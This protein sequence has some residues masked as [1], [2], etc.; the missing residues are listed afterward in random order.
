MTLEKKLHCLSVI[1]FLN[2]AFV[3]QPR[4]HLMANSAPDPRDPYIMGIVDERLIA[5]SD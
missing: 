2:D 4:L 3:K 1:L 5:R